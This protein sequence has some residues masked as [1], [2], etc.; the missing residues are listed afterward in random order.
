MAKNSI[1]IAIVGCGR[2]ADLQC[3]GYQEHPQARIKAVCDPDRR[4]ADKRAKE[5]QVSNVYY[6]YED[7]LKDRSVDAVELLTPHHLHAEMTIEALKAKKHVSLQKPPTCTIEELDAISKAAKSSGFT[8]RVFENFMYYPP[9]I[10]AKQLIAK[11]DIGEPVSIRIKTACGNDDEGWKVD[12][13]SLTWRRDPKKG[14]GGPLTFDHGYHC[15]NMGRFFMPVEIERV[16]AFINWKKIGRN[17]WI[18]G[19]ALISWKYADRIPRYGS[20]EVIE[21]RKMKIRSRYYVSDD[22]IEV[23]GTHGLIWINRCTG[24][25]LDEPSVLLYRDGETRAFHNL[26]ADWVESFRRG[27]IDFVNALTKGNRAPQSLKDARQTLAF[28]LA[29]GKSAAEGREVEIAEILS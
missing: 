19:P 26:K 21:T 13:K 15:F 25:L 1:N 8:V 22:R 7:L 2:I 6:D 24:K 11:G 3:L 23:H 14:G 4:R 28:S 12:K 9:H 20:W 16:H 27:S 10:K 5:W 18:D 29:A 17:S